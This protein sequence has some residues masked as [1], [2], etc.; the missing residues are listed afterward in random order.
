[1]FRIREATEAD[2]DALLRLEAAS[3]QGTGI[4]VNIDR[5]TYFY[6][7]GLFDEGKIL[8][9]E[10]DGHLMG[11]MAYALK[12]V[13]LEGEATRVAYFY[14]LRGDASY[15]R[16]MKRGLFRMWKTIQSEVQDAGVQI[17][18]GHVKADNEDSMRVSTKGGARPAARSCILTLP[19]LSGRPPSVEPLQIEIPEAVATLE[20]A[21]G[22]RDMRPASLSTVYE[23]GAAGGYLSAIYRL[24]EG[25]SRAQI[26]VWDT[27]SIYRGK[28]LRMPFW[29]HALGAVFNPL[30]RRLPVPRIPTV[31]Q[32]ITYWQLFDALSEGPHGKRTLKRLIQWLRYEGYRQG[33]DIVMH[34]YYD[35]DPSFEVPRFV[36]SKTMGYRTMAVPY[37][38]VFP[39]PPLYLDIRDV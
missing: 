14:D 21:V 36:P 25:R 32:Q 37:G 29:L 3:P 27:T 39:R 5:D 6:R 9:G 22:A 10:E 35:P 7:P 33:I 23:K 15:R 11:V 4:T 18:Y 17:L 34:F 8:V 1:M 2:N 26:S 13:L 19:T 16:S 28:V 12:D 24:E 31:G 30:A 20:D 38:D